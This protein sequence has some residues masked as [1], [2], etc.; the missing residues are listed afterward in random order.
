MIH[1]ALILCLSFSSFAVTPEEVRK[2]VLDNFQLIEEAE[3]KLEAARGEET[4]AKGSF[5]T[6]LI[7]KSRNRIE[8]KYDNQYFETTLERNTGLKGINLIAGHRQ[9]VGTFPAYDGKY[10]TSAAGELFA[11]I[12]IPLLRN[13]STDEARANLEVARLEKKQEEEQLKLKKNIYVHKALSLYYKYILE[14]QKLKIRNDILKLALD[15]NEMLEVKFNRGDVERIKLTDNQRSIDK[16]KDELLKTEVYLAELRAQLSL[17]LPGAGENLVTVAPTPIETA[18]TIDPKLKLD[19][20]PQV[21]ILSYEREKGKVLERLR[22]QEK[23]PGLSV[24]VLGAKELSVSPYDPESLQLGVKFDFPLENR[25][26]EGKSVAQSYKLQAIEKR[27]TYVEN[28]ISQSYDFTLRALKL[29]TDRWTVLTNEVERSVAMATAE[30][31]RWREG[32]SDLFTVNLREQDLADVEIRKWTTWYEF[33]Q[34]VLDAK[35]F[36]ASI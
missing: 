23:L 19:E 15:R 20:L 13:F 2:I 1:L 31:N 21:K 17:Y 29:L 16:R 22:E 14:Q 6:K 11:G 32:S 7:F 34:T 36:N 25:K 9:G 28:E 30:R 26:A 4:A 35:L 12:S 27:K 33:H 5:D 24:D 8:D 3:L 18:P 10:A